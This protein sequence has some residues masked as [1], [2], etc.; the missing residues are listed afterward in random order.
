MVERRQ[1]HL[2]QGWRRVDHYY[3]VTV[4]YRFD[5]P[6]HVAG[7]DAARD[8]GSRGRRQDVEAQTGAHA[9]ELVE[10]LL[11]ASSGRGVP[12]PR[13]PLGDR[14]RTAVA[15]LQRSPP[16]PDRDRRV[17]LLPSDRLVPQG[18][19]R[20]TFR[21]SLR[22]PTQREHHRFTPARVT[23]TPNPPRPHGTPASPIRFSWFLETTSS[24]VTPFGVVWC[25]PS[26]V[27]ARRV[28]SGDASTS[29]SASAGLTSRTAMTSSRSRST[30]VLR[31]SSVRAAATNT[32][33]T[34]YTTSGTT[35]YGCSPGL[36]R[37]LIKGRIGQRRRRPSRREGVA[38]N[39][40][41]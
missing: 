37:P 38:R 40:R 6:L 16:T 30:R 33:S 5:H 31:V 18:S 11:S 32:A 9:T 29:R 20:R 21:R 3:V 15:A 19:W 2:I 27:I 12:R 25:S 36:P 26:L 4:D 1:D 7:P 39:A 13:Q 10:A 8:P 14:S 22:S 23:A 41:R 34:Q 17:T 24:G 35:S 28:P